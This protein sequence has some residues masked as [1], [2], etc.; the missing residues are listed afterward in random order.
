MRV[1]EKE[2]FLCSSQQISA[3]SGICEE[4]KAQI[5]QLSSSSS[6]QNFDFSMFKYYFEMP[7]SLL[8][9]EMNNSI[10]INRTTGCFVLL[11]LHNL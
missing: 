1:S 3:V 5:T 10:I 4:E 11:P 9:Y 6:F 8:D 7:P 2:N